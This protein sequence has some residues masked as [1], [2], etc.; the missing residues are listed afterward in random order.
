VR[1]LR[2]ATWDAASG[3]AGKSTTRGTSTDEGVG[4]WGAGSGWGWGVERTWK[5]SVTLSR[6]Q[7]LGWIGFCAK[8]AE[9]G[10]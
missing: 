6:V 5:D 7:S 9:R 1:D 4:N 8:A 3:H 2:A 10:R